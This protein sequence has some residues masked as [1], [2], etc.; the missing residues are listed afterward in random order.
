MSS[1]SPTLSGLSHL[2]SKFFIRSRLKFSFPTFHHKLCFSSGSRSSL[3]SHGYEGEMEFISHQGKQ[4]ERMWTRSGQVLVWRGAILLPR[5]NWLCGQTKRWA[6]ER[7]RALMDGEDS[8]RWGGRLLFHFNSGSHT[9]YS[10]SICW[11][12]LGIFF[13]ELLVLFRP[14]VWRRFNLILLV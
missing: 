2:C 14:S 12:S 9:H 8:G 13:K 11:L 6:L 7:L 3:Q 10:K 4:L 1:D 5:P